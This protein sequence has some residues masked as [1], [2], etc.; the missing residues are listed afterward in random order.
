MGK[1]V[2]I[3]NG[4]DRSKT[5][6]AGA[7]KQIQFN[8]NGVFGGAL[9]EYD[10]TNLNLKGIVLQG[11]SSSGGNLTLMSTAHAT[12]GKILFGTS[13]YDE[14]NNRLGIGTVTPG[15]N[16]LSAYQNI[17]A[18]DMNTLI[19]NA[20]TTG[21]YITNQ[22]NSKYVGNVFVGSSQ[23]WYIGEFGTDNFIIRDHTGLNNSFQ[24]VPGAP[25]NSFYMGTAGRIGVGTALPTA[26]LHLKAGTAT[27][28]TAPLKLTTG[29]DLTTAETGA[30]EY[31]GT[32]LHFTP[33]GTLRE[34]IHFGSK[35]SATLTT[36]TT[37]TITTAGAKA[38]SVILIQPTSAAITLLGV[39][40]SAKNAGSFVLTHTVAAGTEGFDW[41]IIN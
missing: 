21:S 8:D 7:N 26:N 6:P 4:V 10:G 30:M 29:T 41:V 27:A 24:I 1:V 28:N 38:T 9:L 13:A 16:I 14:V 40:I 31:D 18:V 39:Y 15:N 17:P 19:R 35:G 22:A 32:N 11:N 20:Q 2:E 33:T 36:G 12:K 34:N 5:Y 25:I 37:T 3:I 23:Q